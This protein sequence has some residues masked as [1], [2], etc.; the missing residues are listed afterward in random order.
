MILRWFNPAHLLRTF[1]SKTYAERIDLVFW[2]AVGAVS[3]TLLWHL[4]A[5]GRIW[6]LERGE[7]AFTHLES[8]KG[9][10]YIAWLSLPT[11][12]L[13]VMFW[14]GYRTYL[15]GLVA[16][17]DAFDIQVLSERGSWTFTYPTGKLSKNDLV[18]PVARP[19]RLIMSSKDAVHGLAIPELRLQQLSIPGRYNTLWFNIPSQRTLSTRC[20]EGCDPRTKAE[21]K[22]VAIDESHFDTWLTTNPKLAPAAPVK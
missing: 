8:H 15:D 1:D 10:N 20:T 14:L 11:I 12:V 21:P 7:G 9:P 3:W 5:L 18:V 17:A 6:F 19:V 13:V 16:P 2:A 22:V 4:A